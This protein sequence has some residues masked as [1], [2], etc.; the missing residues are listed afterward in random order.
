M[1]IGAEHS[2]DPNKSSKQGSSR[3]SAFTG[4]QIKYPSSA[5]AIGSLEDT[6]DIFWLEHVLAPCSSGA[7]ADGLMGK[8]PQL[9]VYPV[10]GSS[11][12]SPCSN[13]FRA[14]LQVILGSSLIWCWCYLSVVIHLGACCKLS[15]FCD[16]YN[17]RILLEY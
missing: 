12:K 4:Q 3:C 11:C 16:L 2:R 1:K 6:G 15:I 9:S 13:A 7:R 14:A 17:L 5:L 8:G 10:R